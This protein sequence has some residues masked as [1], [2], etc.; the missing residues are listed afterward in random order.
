VK[1]VVP[2]S[3][4]HSTCPAG[5]PDPVADTACIF[6]RWHGL[7]APAFY[8]DPAVR[9]DFAAAITKFLTHTNPAT[10]RAS[11]DD[12]TI[13]AW[14]NCDGCGQGI[15]PKILADWTEFVGRTIKL[16]DTRHL[17]ENG[18]F[19]GR[20]GTHPND[21]P[22]ALLALP[23]VDMLGDRVMPGLDANGAAVNDAVDAV[24]RA[25][26]IYVIDAYGWTPAQWTV[27]D[28]FQAFLK[29]IIKNRAIAGAFVSDLSGHAEAGGY[30]PPGTAAAPSGPALYF[31]GWTTP[32]ADAATMQ[33]RS[34]AVRRLSFGMNDLLTQP[35]VNV[36]QPV[37]L[38]AA[39]G[40]LV[41]RGAAGAVSYGIARSADIA[42]PGSWTTLC[43]QC[44]TDAQPSWQDP[45]PPATGPVWY[46]MIPYNANAHAGMYSDPVKDR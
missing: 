6:A 22:A 4:G 36:D 1:I 5:T 26:R 28:D 25:N 19:A 35:F 45:S 29:A 30:L 11:R 12:P 27:Q 42:T 2:L 23:T 18:A 33:A 16:A 21:V 31:P 37:I 20:L 32:A 13:M 10:G 34:R 17:Y 40:K 44:V 14:E 7:D 43:E 38:S 24:T 8:T 15:D 46:R 41:W 39:H 9:A 3:G